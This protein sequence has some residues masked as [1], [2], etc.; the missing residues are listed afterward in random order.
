MYDYMY[1]YGSIGESD[2]K[3]Q[4]IIYLKREMFCIKCGNLIEDESIF[5]SSCGIR[6]QK[7]DNCGNF[8][9][10]ESI[11]CSS[12]GIRLQKCDNCGNLIE[13]D[14]IYCNNCGIKI[15]K[16][17][18]IEE[19]RI[20]K[21][22]IIFPILGIIVAEIL[23]S[24]EK[25]FSGLSIH[26]FNLLGII[27]FIIFRS[28]DTKIKYLFQSLILIILLRITN[29]SMPQFF[30]ITLDWFPLVYG[31]MFLPI[32][33]TIKYQNIDI[34]I[35]FKKLYIYIPM[36]III[37][38][39]LAIVEYKILTPNPL[40]NNDQISNILLISIIMFAFVGI[41]EELIFRSILQTRL[42]KVIGLRYGLLITSFIFGIMH[43]SHGFD[44]LLFVTNFGIILGYIY[45]KTNSLPFIVSIHGIENILLYGIL[46]FNGSMIFLR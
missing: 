24:Y 4:I 40:I 19:K 12:C 34:G 21:K 2:Q 31:V 18:I 16:L 29:L 26:I 32:Y 41:V 23:I 3:Y 43:Y 14:T 10:D 36:S 9:E 13:E 28:Q 42:Q 45:M 46:P 7:C 25:I 11:F 33:Q 27:L 30:T 35:N 44:E 22:E 38:F 20:S 5:C 1:N 37:G 8:L 15:S 39:F 17:E 6:L